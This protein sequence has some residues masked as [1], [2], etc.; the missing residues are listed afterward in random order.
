MGSEF[1]YFWGLVEQRLLHLGQHFWFAFEKYADY[2]SQQLF[3]T[4]QTFQRLGSVPQYGT[5][6]ERHWLRNSHGAKKSFDFFQ[7]RWL[8]AIPIRSPGQA[9]FSISATRML[10]HPN[11]RNMAAFRF[12]AVAD[13]LDGGKCIDLRR[14][15]VHENQVKTQGPKLGQR[16]L[17]IA[18]NDHL[19][20]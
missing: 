18:G 10:G 14:F 8:G 17:A 12:F 16:L 20:I 11:D 15:H 6:P 1:Q 3:V 7:T 19:M 2:F 9:E 4:L 13:C 5:S